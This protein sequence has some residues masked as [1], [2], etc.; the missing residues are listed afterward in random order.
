MSES[1]FGGI[2]DKVVNHIREALKIIV[3]RAKEFIESG[4][5]A[6]LGRYM[7]LNHGLL[8]AFGL[9][10]RTA[11]T[12]FEAMLDNGVLGAKM[13]CKEGEFIIGIVNEEEAAINVVKKMREEGFDTFY[14]KI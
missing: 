12:A 7:V 10:S 13:S 11:G 2:D 3:K 6:L 1:P 14:T 4:D 5:F 8:V 9:S